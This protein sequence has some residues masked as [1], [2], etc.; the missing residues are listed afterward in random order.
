[1]SEPHVWL[2]SS[3]EHETLMV[4]SG[5]QFYWTNDKAGKLAAR[6]DQVKT[7][8]DPEKVLP[9]DGT[10]VPVK[11]V[12]TIRHLRDE[13]SFGVHCTAENGEAKELYVHHSNR[14]ASADAARNLATTLGLSMHRE[15]PATV[16]EITTVPA[17]VGVVLLSMLGFLY[18]G[19][20]GSDS[21]DTDTQRTGKARALA[22]LAKALGPNGILIA[23]A[24]VAIGVGGYWYHRFTHRPIADVY[25][26]QS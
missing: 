10:W 26:R 12:K 9:K 23:M 5:D 6:A 8:A 18:A 22:G 1:M 17:I 4:L 15:M 24:V 3:S 16:G 19:I 7:G 20:S 21:E 25:E 14:T 2:S 13:S 11:H